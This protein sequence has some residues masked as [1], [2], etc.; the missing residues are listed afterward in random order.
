M[1]GCTDTPRRAPGCRTTHTCD[2]RGS[3]MP[4]SRILDVV[5]RLGTAVTT[6]ALVVLGATAGVAVAVPA[7]P[8]TVTV[9]YDR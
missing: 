4:A 3:R 1:T 8:P 2:T 9:T 6:A 7:E 5:A